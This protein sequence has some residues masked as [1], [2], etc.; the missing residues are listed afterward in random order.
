ML[1][2][3][4]RRRSIRA[5]TADAVTDEQV[6]LLLEAAMAAPTAHNLQPWRFII[7]RDPETR[8]ALAETHEFSESLRNAPVVIAVCADSS[9]AAHWLEDACVA[10]ENILLQAVELN[11]GCTWVAVYPHR[12]HESYVCGVLEIP[13][14]VRIICLI[15]VGHPAE[16]KPP[17][18]Q[19]DSE[20]VFSERYG[21]IWART[22]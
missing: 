19:Y 18:T 3:M 2:L 6:Q 7:V 9:S 4:K 14:A 20:K 12:D 8:A 10:V 11:L 13:E 15:P 21:T 17:R 5:F 22:S 16:E 1:D